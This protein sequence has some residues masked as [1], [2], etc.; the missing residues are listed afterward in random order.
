MIMISDDD[1]RR[2]LGG[3]RAYCV[4]ILHHGPNYQ[5]LG[6]EKIIW[7]HAR[8]NFAMRAAGD[9]PIVCA[10]R[11]G[12]DVSGIGIFNGSV[13][14]VRRL[15]DDDPGVKAGTFVYEVHVARSFPGDRLPE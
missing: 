9:L 13:D 14:E 4:V 12:S 7:E 10:I 6:V 5:Q 2:M 15:M 8:R 3:A 1:M 11:D